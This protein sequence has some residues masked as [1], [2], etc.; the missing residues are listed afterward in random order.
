MH[1]NTNMQPFVAEKL[2]Q[3]LWSDARDTCARGHFLGMWQL[4]CASESLDACKSFA[5]SPVDVHAQGE[6]LFFIVVQDCRA[7]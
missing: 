3:I 7:I 1:T 5:R 2:M 4:F 6:T